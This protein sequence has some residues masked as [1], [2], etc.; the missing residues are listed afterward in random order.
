MCSRKSHGTNRSFWCDYIVVAALPLPSPT[1]LTF[2]QAWNQQQQ[3]PAHNSLSENLVPKKNWY[4]KWSE[5]EV[6]KTGFKARL[7]VIFIFQLVL[8]YRK[9]L[10]INTLQLPVAMQLLKDSLVFNQGIF[11][12]EDIWPCLETFLVVTMSTIGTMWVEI[13]N[14]AKHIIMHKTCLHKQRITN[15]KCQQY[16][17][18]GILIYIIEINTG[19]S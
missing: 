2:P 17:G 9:M 11:P 4:H 15:P 16:W 8:I 5:D 7:F 14:T 1:S 18:S 10:D 13:R 12:S 3:L 6:F 19:C